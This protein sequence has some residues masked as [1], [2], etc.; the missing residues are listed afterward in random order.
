MRPVFLSSDTSMHFANL[1]NAFSL[2]FAES[3]IVSLFLEKILTP[4][5]SNPHIS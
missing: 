2:I 3:A 4:D 5:L 1:E